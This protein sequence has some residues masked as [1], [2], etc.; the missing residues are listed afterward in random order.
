MTKQ[1]LKKLEERFPKPKR[2]SNR[3]FLCQII[4]ECDLVF[5]IWSLRPWQ[6]PLL[7]SPWS[8]TLVYFL[9]SAHVIRYIFWGFP[10]LL[11]VF[12]AAIAGE[13]CLTLLLQYI[14]FAGN[15]LHTVSS[16]CY[17]IEDLETIT[18]Q[19]CE[20]RES[21][22]GPENFETK[23]SKIII[24]RKSTFKKVSSGRWKTA[25]IITLCESN[26]LH[27]IAISSRYRKQ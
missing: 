27:L 9:F 7:W 12:S 4:K 8:A 18:E 20:H 15:T 13:T 21:E 10:V 25:I 24:F 26:S 2:V 23:Y 3:P 11:L 5:P 6:C 14:L 17:F 22:S 19:I 1:V 16:L